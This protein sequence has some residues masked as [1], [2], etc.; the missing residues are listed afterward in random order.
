[1]LAK[2]I[3]WL[4]LIA[5]LLSA[6]NALMRYFFDW[7]ANWLLELQWLLFAAVFLLTASYC[8]KIH[9]HVRIDVLI[10]HLQPKTRAWIDLIGLLVFLCPLCVLVLYES[11][12]FAWLSIRSQ[13]MSMNAGG[14]ALWPAK[15]LIPIGF[16]FLLLQGISE[17]IKRFAFLRGQISADELAL[18]T[19]NTEQE[20]S[21][22]LDA[23]QHKNLLD[24]KEAV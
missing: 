19:H 13:E 6:G 3:R 24:K 4:I 1:M 20:I 18:V 17:L 2:S 15:A 23:A 8:L 7:S 22:H 14:L 9:A 21:Q 10:N 16:A 5:V 11:I 12:P